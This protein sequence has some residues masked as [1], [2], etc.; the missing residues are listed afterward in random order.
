MPHRSTPV[1]ARR[2]AFPVCQSRKSTVRGR[3]V[4]V[5]A[6]GSGVA[7]ALGRA[8]GATVGTAVGATV[9]VS[10]GSTSTA[11]AVASV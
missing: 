4:A 1:A 9:G 5:G 11:T 7:V 3:V 2:I 10:V 8:V 6:G